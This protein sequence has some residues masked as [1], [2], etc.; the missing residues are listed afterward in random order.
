MYIYSM[1]VF[2]IISAK[3]KNKITKYKETLSLS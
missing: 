1:Y 3:G 2:A